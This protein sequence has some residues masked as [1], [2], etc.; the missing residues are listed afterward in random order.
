MEREVERYDE[1]VCWRGRCVGEEGVLERRGRC[2]REEGVLE[3]KVCWRGE[4]G[5]LER[6][7]C[8]RGGC[9]REEGVL[10][11]KYEMVC[12][13][14]LDRACEKGAY[15]ECQSV[16]EERGIMC[17]SV[18]VSE[19]MCQRIVVPFFRVNLGKAA[20]RTSTYSARVC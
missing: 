3:R 20:L 8:W 16:C 1:R 10:E 7:V 19:R 5:V 4:E 13:R 15:G 18:V 12:Y 11:R 17:G 6:K 14:V 2:V 9:V